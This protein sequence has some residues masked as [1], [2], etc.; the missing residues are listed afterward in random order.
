MLPIIQMELTTLSCNTAFDYILGTIVY[1]SP[2]GSDMSAYNLFTFQV[3]VLHKIWF[4]VLCSLSHI[5]TLRPLDWMLFEH[6]S[7]SC[8][9]YAI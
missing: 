7:T 3:T 1:K 4:V 8:N 2:I 9:I 6:K 5:T